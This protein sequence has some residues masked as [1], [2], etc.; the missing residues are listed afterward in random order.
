MLMLS[1]KFL[2]NE[3]RVSLIRIKLMDEQE[4]FHS[5]VSVIYFHRGQGEIQAKKIN[6]ISPKKNDMRLCTL[7]V[8]DVVWCDAG[9]LNNVHATPHQTST[10]S[11]RRPMETRTS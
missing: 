2:I 4:D 9:I 6:Q 3:T 11:L 10:S 5:D 1:D 7:D 8:H